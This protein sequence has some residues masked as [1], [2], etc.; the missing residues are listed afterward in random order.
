MSIGRESVEEAAVILDEFITFVER[1]PDEKQI[2]RAYVSA[3]SSLAYRNKAGHEEI[4]FS[5]V[6]KHTKRFIGN[7]EIQKIYTDLLISS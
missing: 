5:T 1:Y 2:Q 6:E 4:V 7:V 3:M